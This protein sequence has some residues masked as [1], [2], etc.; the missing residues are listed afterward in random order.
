MQR[1]K[2]ILFFFAVAAIVGALYIAVLQLRAGKVTEAPV[3]TENTSEN[4][5]IA[6]T[7]AKAIETRRF[8]V[9]AL[10]N[11]SIT[12]NGSLTLQENLTSV[13]ARLI[14]APNLA[15][16]ENYELYVVLGSGEQVFVS[17]FTYITSSTERYALGAS[18]QTSWFKARKILVTKRKEGASR[19]G[20]ILAEAEMTI[21]D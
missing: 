1:T 19:P 9:Q 4:K 10:D 3:T 17:T 13:G 18:G 11:S 5:K 12:G 21:K 15:P 20:T 2:F 6:G 14:T 16:G 8:I 7:P